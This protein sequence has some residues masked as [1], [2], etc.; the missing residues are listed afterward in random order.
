[1][2]YWKS[3]FT[4]VTK[5]KRKPNNTNR[6]SNKHKQNELMCESVSFSH[7]PHS[8]NEQKNTQ[9]KKTKI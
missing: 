2:Q 5:F 8:R 1:M 9:P 3:A 7:R 6:Q 4:Q